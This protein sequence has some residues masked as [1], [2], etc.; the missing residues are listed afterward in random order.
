MRQIIDVDVQGAGEQQKAEHAL[1]QGQIEIH[2][3]DDIPGQLGDPGPADAAQQQQQQR[4]AQADQHQTDGGGQAQVAMID[5][6][7]QRCQ[8]DD[9]GEGIERRHGSGGEK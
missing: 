3:A 7:E 6:A 8:A 4:Q 5:I 9:Q 1:H 2:L